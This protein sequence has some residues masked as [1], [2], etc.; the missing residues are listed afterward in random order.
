MAYLQDQ[1]LF[2]RD[3]NEVLNVNF[4]EVLNGEKNEFKETINFEVKDAS[5]ENQIRKSNSR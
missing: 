5:N 2:D 4:S 1:Y 3:S